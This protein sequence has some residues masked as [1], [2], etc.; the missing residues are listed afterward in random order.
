M[1]AGG[2]EYEGDMA[3]VWTDDDHQAIRVWNLLERNGGIDWAGLPIVVE[4]LGI[5]DV[6]GLV[7]RLQAIKSH[8][9]KDKT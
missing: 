4:L 1:Q 5:S 9:R 8:T 6:D 3:P 7:T 2:I